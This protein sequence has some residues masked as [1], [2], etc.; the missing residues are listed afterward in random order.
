MKNKINYKLLFALLFGF[1]CFYA[2]KKSSTARVQQFNIS[3]TNFVADTAGFGAVRIDPNLLDAWGLARFPGGPIWIAANHSGSS[4]V[5]DTTGNTVITPVTIPSVTAGQPGA[6][7]GMVY[8]NTTD[9]GGNLFLFAS[10]EGIV[11][12]W[13]SGA[14]AT[15]FT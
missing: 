15:S 3:Q 1:T 8:N 11:L 10:E 7:S 4:V 12:G 14:A 2:C 9:F 5:Y 13:K 6:P